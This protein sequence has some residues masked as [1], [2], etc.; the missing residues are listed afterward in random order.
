ML[1]CLEAGR[2]IGL[3]RRARDPEGADAGT[4]GIDSALSVNVH[5]GE[6]TVGPTG[7]HGWLDLIGETVNTCATL[8]SR[9]FGISQQAFRRLTPEHRRLFHKFSPPVIYQPEGSFRAARR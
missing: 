1:A 5:F 6:V 9:T 2:R 7:L 8:G 4:G 3:A